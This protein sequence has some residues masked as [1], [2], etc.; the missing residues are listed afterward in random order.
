MKHYLE[1]KD[2]LLDKLKEL[3]FSILSG[4]D[5]LTKE[6][7]KEFLNPFEITK[8]IVDWKVKYIYKSF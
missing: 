5:I 3:N 1:G 7:Q 6:K 4:M 2:F 8:R